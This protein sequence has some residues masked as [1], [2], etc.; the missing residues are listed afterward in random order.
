MSPFFFLSLFCFYTKQFCSSKKK[1]KNIFSVQ[2]WVS[3]EPACFFLFTLL[4][5]LYETKSYFSK[6]ISWSSTHIFSKTKKL[7][8]IETV[9]VF[10]KTCDENRQQIHR[11]FPP[12]ENSCDEPFGPTQELW[13]RYIS[14]QLDTKAY[15]SLSCASRS[16]KN[17]QT[18]STVSRYKRS[19]GVWAPREY[20]AIPT[21]SIS[22][23]Q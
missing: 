15:L 2:P 12:Y 16:V 9:F 7:F 3:L 21:I 18:G 14:R 10:W 19:F 1:T 23:I 20:G 22:G 8:H 13:K 4:L 17:C 11:P 6:Q 5:F